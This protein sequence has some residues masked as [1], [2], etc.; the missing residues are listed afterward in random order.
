MS[1][2]ETIT[3]EENA[4]FTKK[5]LTEKSGLENAIDE[6]LAQ[7]DHCVSV[8]SDEYALM[9]I[10]LEK[11]YKLKEIDRE[12]GP[13]WNRVNAD[14]VVKTGGMLIGIGAIVVYE[15]KNVMGSK[16]LSFVQKLL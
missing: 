16:A 6:I 12:N 11:L 15:Q 10:Q 2:N 13:F 4:L 1:F 7:M 9:S 8:D 3:R 14:T 5:T